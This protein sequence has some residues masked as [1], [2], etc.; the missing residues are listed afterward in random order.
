MRRAAIMGAFALSVA[1]GVEQPGATEVVAV[2]Q[3]APPLQPVLIMSPMAASVDFTMSVEDMPPGADVWFV[4]SVNGVGSGPCHPVYGACASIQGPLVVIGHRT[5]DAAG[6]ALV[7]RRVPAN[8]DFRVVAAQALVGDPLTGDAAFS[9]IEARLIGDWDLDVVHDSN[10]NCLYSP[11]PLQVNLDG[12]AFGEVCDCDDGDDTIFPG[13]ADA[14]GDGIDQDCDG[15]D[16]PQVPA[17]I[18]SFAGDAAFEFSVL[19]TVVGCQAPIDLELDPTATPVI[20]G[21]T[22]CDV[23]GLGLQVAFNLE[24]DVDPN[25]AI[26]GV[27]DDGA[28]TVLPWTGTMSGTAPDRVI[29]GEASGTLSVLGPFSMDFETFEL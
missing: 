22:L 23:G 8:Q 10:D 27:M 28:G 17:E 15:T 12:D 13:A 7:T 14:V 25:G 9:D 1:C 6:V 20:T 3:A 11:N 4:L 18:G 2:E 29:A 21:N 24:G 16:G 26:T 19:G 5:V